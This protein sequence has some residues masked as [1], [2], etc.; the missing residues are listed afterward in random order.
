[1]DRSSLNPLVKRSRKRICVTLILRISTR[2]RTLPELS[3]YGFWK[4][5]KMFEGPD[6]HVIEGMNE[7]LQGHVDF[8][9]EMMSKLPMELSDNMVKHQLKLADRQCRIA[10]LSQR[11][12]NTVI[13]LVTCLY[14]HE[15]GNEVLIQSADIL[16]QTCDAT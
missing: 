3:K 13:M 14:A 9:M 16:C 6:Q 5:G 4:A 10:E 15:Q 8:V 11:V 1:M 2:D 12:Q 7:R